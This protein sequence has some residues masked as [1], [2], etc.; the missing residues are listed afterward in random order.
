MKEWESIRVLQSVAGNA[1]LRRA[2]AGYLCFATAEFGV[3]VAILFYGYKVD[4]AKGA[5]VAA[6]VQLIPATIFAPSSA[7][8]SAEIEPTLP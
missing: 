6:L 8:S 2:L 5:A 4:G 3:W 1:S 7:M